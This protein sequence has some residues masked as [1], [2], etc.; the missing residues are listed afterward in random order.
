MWMKLQPGKNNVYLWSLEWVLYFLYTGKKQD[1]KNRICIMLKR[2]VILLSLMTLIALSCSGRRSNRDS[3]NIEWWLTLTDKSVLFQKQSGPLYA[4]EAADSSAVININDSLIYQAIDGFGYTLTGGSAIHI[5]S[6]DEPERLDL[7][8]ELFGTGSNSIGV[9]YLRIS[10]GAS[11]LSDHVFSYD[12]M[13]RGTTD[14]GLE[15]FSID[16]ERKDLIP[17]LK[18]ILAIHPDLKILGSPWSPPAWMK[19][20]QDSRGGSLKKEW[21]GTYANYFVKYIRA[22]EQEGIIIDAI[23]IQ[24]EPLHPGNNPSL[25][26]LPE[27]QLSFLKDHLGPAFQ[28]AGI[29]TK[30]ILYDHNADRIDYPMTI[31]SDPEA[32]PYADGSAFH[33]YGGNIEDLSKVH[34]A[35]P[36]KN[37]YF[38]EQWVG[39]PGDFAGD[40]SWH[41][42]TLIIGATRNWCRTVLEWNLS[43][44]PALK[45]FTDRGGCSRCLG[46]VTIDGN[47]VTRN[48]A[49]YV[50]AHASK[51]VRP[52]S[53]HIGSNIPMGL[54]NVAFKTPEGSLVMIVQNDTPETRQFTVRYSQGSFRAELKGGAVATYVINEMSE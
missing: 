19:D 40:F 17:V 31:L 2:T 32:Y 54:N 43:S 3:G 34:E 18:Q 8:T 13:P 38:T 50:I 12:D 44:N 22:M 30:I 11:D 41:I 42:R 47:T 53:V 1:M 4:D 23:T 49:Y 6:M 28:K 26:M 7:L 36:E 24:N 45:P 15:H 5:N 46:A 52:G 20:N 9:S 48:P 51:F 25:L 35:F 16:P 27:D 14:P 29:K 10:I 37:L 39:A 33:L 21:Y